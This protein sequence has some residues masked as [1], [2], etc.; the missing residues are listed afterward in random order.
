MGGNVL[1]GFG[2]HIAR[3]RNWLYWFCNQGEEDL[4]TSIHLL[5][6]LAQLTNHPHWL[7]TMGAISY[8]LLSESETVVQ[9]F[10][11]DFSEIKSS[12]RK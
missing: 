6:V 2:K 11:E 9:N 1:Q 4:N 3:K 7:F 8:S 5:S 12:V 10:I